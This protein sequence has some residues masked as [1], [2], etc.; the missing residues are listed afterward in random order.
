M[1]QIFTLFLLFSVG[2]LN[3]Q[4]VETV[5]S[6]SK[7]VD[8]LHVDPEGIVYTTSGGL[9]GG[10]EIGKYDPS[11]D[12]FNPFFASGLFGPINIGQ[13]QDSLF[14]ITN[15]DNNTVSRYNLN[16]GIVDVLATSL[17]GPAGIA[18]DSNDNIFVTNFGAPPTYSGHVITKITPE[19]V[20]SV[21]I[22]SS[23][24]FR[25]QAICFNHEGILV[26]HSEES[27]YKVNAADSSLVHWVTLD[28]GVGNMILRNQD[29]CIYASAGGETDRIIRVDP[30][31]AVS[32]FSGSSAGYLD[33]D[34]DEA[35]FSNPLGLAFSPS[36]DTLYVSEA[37]GSN[38][39]RRILFNQV[40]GLFVPLISS[41]SF[42]PNPVNETIHIQSGSEKL[43]IQIRNSAGETVLIKNVFV[44]HSSINIQHLS[45]GI[46]FIELTNDSER[47]VRK[48]VKN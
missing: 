21:Y 35:L 33:G 23:A 30:D 11:T 10:N 40:S 15:F 16:T 13:Y 28:H 6:H 17:D 7:I 26:V 9:V 5:T 44:K 25:I 43:S 48:I 1:K 12:I 45:P 34:I 27:L 2:V 29:S 20:A 22:D 41:I 47:L 42:Y 19:G 38:R 37:A 3:A 18:I 46:Y 32:V 36:E 14:A 24:L 8:G 4:Q 31:G 39:L